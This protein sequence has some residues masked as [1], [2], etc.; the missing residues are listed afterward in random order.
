MKANMKKLMGA[1]MVVALAV[2]CCPMLAFAAEEA[3]VTGKV[4]DIDEVKERFVTKP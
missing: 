2:M 3:R 4:V 1:M